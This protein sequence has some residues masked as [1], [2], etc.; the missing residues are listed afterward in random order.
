MGL[1]CKRSQLLYTLIAALFIKSKN[2]TKSQT[3][4]DTTCFRAKHREKLE[5]DDDNNQKSLMSKS[6][7][8]INPTA[9]VYFNFFILFHLYFTFTSNEY[10]NIF[11]K[12]KSHFSPIS[13]LCFFHYILS[14]I[15]FLNYKNATKEI[16]IN[17]N[18]LLWNF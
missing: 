7:K 3:N 16:F 2:I 18:L 8:N 14:H 1:W 10:R 6:S 9:A 5:D 12:I 15:L 17:T 4:C 11:K 13:Q